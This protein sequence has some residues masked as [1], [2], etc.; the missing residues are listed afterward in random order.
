M[1]QMEIPGTAP[2][3]VQLAAW[4]GDRP[5]GGRKPQKAADEGLFAPAAPDT[6]PDMFGRAAK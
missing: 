2:S 1:K 4:C 3:G 5:N 6:S